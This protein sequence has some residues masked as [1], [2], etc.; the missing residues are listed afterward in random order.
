MTSK[1][2]QLAKVFCRTWTEALKKVSSSL[3][4][5][6]NK[7]P[8]VCGINSPVIQTVKE[9]TKDQDV[10]DNL[11]KMAFDEIRQVSSSCR[12]G[13][14]KWSH[15]EEFYNKDREN[16]NRVCSSFNPAPLTTSTEW[17]TENQRA[18]SRSNFKPF[19]C[20]WNICQKEGGQDAPGTTGAGQAFRRRRSRQEV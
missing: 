4:A 1:N 19:G 6:L 9:I 11:C 3:K 2:H 8:M 15:I 7:I 20:S 16:P 10:N 18:P 13:T 14:V 12:G 5:L 17:Q